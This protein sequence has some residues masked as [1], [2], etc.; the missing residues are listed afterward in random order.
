MDLWHRQLPRHAN[1]ILSE[2]LSITG[3]MG[4]VAL[5]PL[6]L[7]C[8]A[9]VRAKTS[10]AAAALQRDPEAARDLRA[11][12]REYFSL[13][14]RLLD[15]APHGL[16]AVGGYSGSGKSTLAR[17]LVPSLGA[18]PGAVVVRSDVVR[19]RLQGVEPEDRLGPDGYT[20][21]ADR[22]VYAALVTRALD[23]AAG[24]HAAIVDAVY[25][26]AADREAIERAAMAAGVPFVGLW[27]DAPA[28]VLTTRVE[29]RSGDASD[30]DAG[31]V[32]AQVA[33]DAGLVTWHRLDA[34]MGA[35]E[36]ERAACEVLRARLG[37]GVASGP[38][39]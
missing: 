31:V 2:Y 18:V 6:F 23:V 35:L 9:A 17:A 24:G 26:R 20:A 15:P 11:A 38:G 25:A 37:G 39:L 21:E 5:L 1:V 4:G 30:A 27:L 10:I 36:V 3:D 14:E 22:Q 12:A 8:R 34:G 29:R 16:V 13:A 32:R 19:K 7:S 28:P 33:Q